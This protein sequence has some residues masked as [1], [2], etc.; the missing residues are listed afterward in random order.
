MIRTPTVAVKDTYARTRWIG[1]TVIHPHAS[2]TVTISQVQYGLVDTSGEIGDLLLGSV[3]EKQS[4]SP[5]TPI[6]LGCTPWP[7]AFEPEAQC[8]CNCRRTHEQESRI[9]S[10]KT[11]REVPL[12]GPALIDN[13]YPRLETDAEAHRI[14][15][16]RMK[17]P[18]AHAWA[19]AGRQGLSAGQRRKRQSDGAAENDGSSACVMPSWMSASRMLMRARVLRKPRV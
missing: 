1:Q 18:S 3:A 4:V 13:T 17:C 16:H 15:S 6:Y 2:T 9:A 12:L 14:A 11:G 10:A 5:Q 19:V 8:L 7:K